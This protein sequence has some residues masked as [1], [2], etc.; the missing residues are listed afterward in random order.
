MDYASNEMMFDGLGYKIEHP[1]ERRYQDQMKIDKILSRIQGGF[2]CQMQMQHIYEW[3]NNHP[4]VL[5]Q[6]NSVQKRTSR[7]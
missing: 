6:I 2:P 1:L 7:K 3:R 5:R 4:Q